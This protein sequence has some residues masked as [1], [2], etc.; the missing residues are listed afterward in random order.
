MDVSRELRR[1]GAHVQIDYLG[2][3]VR[4]PE[5][6]ELAVG[7][8]MELL[9]RIAAD[10]LEAHISLKPTQLGMDLSEELCFRNLSTVVERAAAHGNFVW[11]DMESS[12]YVSR[13]VHAYRGLRDRYANVGIAIQSYLFR[14]RTDVEMLLS[15][16]GTMRLCKGAYMEPPHVAFRHKAEVDSSFAFLSEM[17]L[18]SR[19]VQAFATHDE[20]MIDRVIRLA[21]SKGLEP[22]GY[23]FQL[24]HGVRRDLQRRLLRDG[25]RVRI[26]VPYGSEWFPYFMRRLA[27]RPANVLF[28]LSSIVREARSGE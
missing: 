24:L 15:Q 13:T 7:S 2:E 10:G 25:H 28:M 12:E 22:Q 19:R 1:R 17:L 27:E 9:D 23:E 26:Y 14:T 4:S 11:V 18:S 20:K 5:Q 16:E 6:A 3:N 21:E 8:Y